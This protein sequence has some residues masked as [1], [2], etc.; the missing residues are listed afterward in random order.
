[1]ISTEVVGL[2]CSFLV[3]RCMLKYGYINLLVTQR[4]IINGLVNTPERKKVSSDHI[5]IVHVHLTSLNYQILVV[6]TYDLKIYATKEKKREM[7]MTGASCFSN[8]Y[9][10]TTYEMHCSILT[11]LYLTIYMD[12]LK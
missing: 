3:V 10:D 6:N 11:Y 7:T 9:L 12:L 4:V 2:I 8:P 1:M 5:V